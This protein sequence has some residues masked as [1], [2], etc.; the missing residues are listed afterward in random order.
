MVMERIKNPKTVP[1]CNV[2][3][4]HKKKNHHCTLA[5]ETLNTNIRGTGGGGLSGHGVLRAEVREVGRRSRRWREAWQSAA[6]L[7]SRWELCHLSCET[8]VQN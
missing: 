1:F 6:R 3:Y 4:S 2:E 8:N 5:L 7:E